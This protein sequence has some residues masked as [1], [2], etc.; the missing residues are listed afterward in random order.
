[1][2]RGPAGSVGDTGA[3]PQRTALAWQRTALT[4]VAGAAVTARLSGPGAGLGAAVAVPAA[5]LGLWVA[6][7]GARRH[8][9][10]GGRRRL[11]RRDGRVPFAL[12]LASTAMAGGVLTTLLL[13]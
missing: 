8:G 13:R 4:L 3:S 12:A 2:S 7:A 5:L 10:R 1:M 9:P 6:V 11:V